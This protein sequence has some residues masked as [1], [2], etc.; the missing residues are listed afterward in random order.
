MGSLTLPLST[1]ENEALTESLKQYG[2]KHPILVLPDGRII[3]G[4][5]RWQILAG[6]VPFDRDS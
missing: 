6:K 5:H 4:Y 1:A 2:L 3:D